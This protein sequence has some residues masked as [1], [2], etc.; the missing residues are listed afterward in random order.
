MKPRVRSAII[1]LWFFMSVFLAIISY[2]I[3]H[4]ILKFSI[5]Y[6]IIVL[7]SVLIAFTTGI[8]I[9]VLANRTKG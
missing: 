5:V 1:L 2:L 4:V 9:V 7:A 6:T 8:I 3:A